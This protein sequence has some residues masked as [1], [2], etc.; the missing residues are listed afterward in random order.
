MPEQI[1]RICIKCGRAI[2]DENYKFCPFCGKNLETESQSKR[3][4]D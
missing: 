1:T 4:E 3:E 2:G